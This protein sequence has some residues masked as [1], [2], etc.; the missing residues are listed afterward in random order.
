MLTVATIVC[1]CPVAMSAVAGVITTP[2][3]GVTVIDPVAEK[4][5]SAVDVAR[6]VVEPGV[7][8]VT[9]PAL[10]TVAMVLLP[11]VH[12]TAVDTPG[13]GIKG[14]RKLL[15]ITRADLRTGG[16][17][18]HAADSKHLHRNVCTYTTDTNTN[19][20]RAGVHCSDGRSGSRTG[21]RRHR[22]RCPRST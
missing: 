17:D 19:D 14:R 10:V 20:G 15:R 8:P 11:V 16:I 2:R 3:D 9:T 7:T 12:V 21:H 4:R 18:L 13:I 1:C 5:E 22:W 6:I